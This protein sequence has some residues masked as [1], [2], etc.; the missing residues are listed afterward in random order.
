MITVT[1][2]SGTFWERSPEHPGGEVFVTA[3]RVVEVA[4]TTSVQRAVKQG[5]LSI[6]DE[7]VLEDVPGLAGELAEALRERGIDSV[8]SLANAGND[9]LIAVSGIGPKTAPRLRGAAR[10][11]LEA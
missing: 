7:P 6:V 4:E 9:K 1:A 10:K 5:R 2:D 8:R 11:L 3:G